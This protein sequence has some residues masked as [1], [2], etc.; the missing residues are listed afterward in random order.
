MTSAAAA[1]KR[2]RIQ[3]S[4]SESIASSSGWLVSMPCRW[5]IEKRA[6]FQTL[7]ANAL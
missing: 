5:S 3:R 2:E 6:A 7:F 1:W 4:A